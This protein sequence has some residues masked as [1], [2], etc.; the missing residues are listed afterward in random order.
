M[1]D[2]G[3]VSGCRGEILAKTSVI[4]VKWVEKEG[5]LLGIRKQGKTASMGLSAE[6]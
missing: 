2:R 6:I 5:M 3:Y 4:A 1:G